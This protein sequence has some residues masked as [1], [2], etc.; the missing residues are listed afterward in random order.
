MLYDFEVTLTENNTTT[1][2]IQANSIIQ[3]LDFYQTFSTAT[4]TKIKKV[5]YRSLN[6]DFTDDLY[7]SELKALVSTDNRNTQF[8]IHFVKKNLTK[9]TVMKSIKQN[10]IY[11]SDP[12]TKV[13]NII[14]RKN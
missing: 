11:L 5:V 4:V 8:S 10:I 2:V 13:N 9:D 6:D 12:I 1:L 7:D 3:I 14:V